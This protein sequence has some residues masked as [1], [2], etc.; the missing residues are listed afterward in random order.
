MAR[1]TLGPTPNQI[2]LKRAILELTRRCNLACVHCSREAGYSE[3]KETDTAQWLQIVDQLIDYGTDILILG[4]GEPFLEEARLRAIMKRAISRG[5]LTRITTNG[6]LLHEDLASFIY[7][8]GGVVC[9]GMD[10][11]DE[12]VHDAFRGTKGAYRQLMKSIDLAMGREILDLVAVTA[13]RDNLEQIPKMIDFAAQLGVT[14][15]VSKYVPTG[16]PNYDR[17]LLSA[18]QR[19]QVLE[20]IGEKRRQHPH[21]QI[22][23]TRDPLEAIRYGT[24]AMGLL[25]C[26][27]GTGWCLISATGEVQPCPYLPVVVGNVLE[28]PFG[29]IWELSPHLRALRDRSN[30][31]G[32]CGACPDKESCG[33]CRALAFGLTGD[34]LAPDPQCW[35]R[36]DGQGQGETGH[37]KG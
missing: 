1:V 20:L 35:V 24:G 31:K 5:T 4:G 17:L 8:N 36:G 37:E 34:Y 9:F 30:L 14:C 26:I 29:A 19:R 16:R 15:I 21:I 33:G 2:G 3:P 27:A 6:L 32:K 12:A 13:T 22:T 11:M 7:D 10:G 28:K 23:T 25:G 18:T